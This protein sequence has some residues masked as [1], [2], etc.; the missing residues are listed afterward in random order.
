MALRVYFDGAGK[1]NDHPLVTVG[2]F[3]ADSDTCEEMEYEWTEATCGR[4]FHFTDFGKKSCLLDSKDWKSEERVQFLKELATIVNRPNCYVL[5]TTIEVN[6]YNK[7]VE[8]TPLP[9]EFGPAFSGCAYVAIFNAE[10]ILLNENRQMQP[11]HYIFELGDRQHEISAVF[12]DFAQTESKLYG[13]REH[14]FLPKTT[15][16]LQPADFVAGVVQRTLM[17]AYRRLPTL[18]NGIAR[19]R[20][21]TFDRDYSGDGVTEALVRGHD[22]KHCWIANGQSFRF[23]DGVSMRFFAKHPEQLEKRMKRGGYRPKRPKSPPASS[24]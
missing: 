24:R 5:S 6:E 21:R 9:E 3:L 2:G 22:S 15:V 13:L 10:A 14:N 11:V 18:D 4:V 23:L 17:S 20:L 7:V 19:T 8:S 16:L 12:A 1:E